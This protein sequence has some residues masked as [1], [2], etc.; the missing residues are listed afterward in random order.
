MYIYV[1]KVS[2]KRCLSRKL[3][4]LYNYIVGKYL[5]R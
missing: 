3:H 4:Y 2:S 1:Y 5:N